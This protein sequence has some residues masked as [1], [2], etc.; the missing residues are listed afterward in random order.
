MHNV[1]FCT[2]KSIM[3]HYYFEKCVENVR[4]LSTINFSQYLFSLG[5]KTK[6]LLILKFIDKCVVL[7]KNLI[8]I[9]NIVLRNNLLSSK[10]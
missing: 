9:N 6:N 3:I 4:D 1:F 7:I 5:N 2:E 10:F 8:T